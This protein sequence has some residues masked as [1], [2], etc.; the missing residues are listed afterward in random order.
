[1]DMKELAGS[2]LAQYDAS[3]ADMFDQ[4]LS[5]DSVRFVMAAV[6]P[7]NTR[8]VL[9]LVED[10]HALGSLATQQALLEHITDTAG[11]DEDTLTSLGLSIETNTCTL[12]GRE[13]PGVILT[14]AGDTLGLGAPICQQ[15]ALLMTEDYA[16]QLAMVSLTGQESLEELVGSFSPAP[17]P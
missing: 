2:F 11:L 17:L 4:A 15:T 1:M 13:V 5:S 10:L 6:S 3:Y 7:D 9:A 16:M 8:I 12:A 14:L